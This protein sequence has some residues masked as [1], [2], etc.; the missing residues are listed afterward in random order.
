MADLGIQASVNVESISNQ[1]ADTLLL[2]DSQAETVNSYADLLRV[3][4]TA[5]RA[6]VTPSSQTDGTYLG[7]GRRFTDLERNHFHEHNITPGQ[8]CTAYFTA[9]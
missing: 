2:E 7:R 8:P 1:S 4:E 9:L 6:E 5:T 3:C